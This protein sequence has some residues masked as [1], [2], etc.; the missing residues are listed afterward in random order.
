MNCRF[1]EDH[2]HLYLYGELAAAEEENVEAHLAACAHCT[3]LLRQEKAL[4]AL[5]KEEDLSAPVGLLARNRQEL[6]DRLALAP[7][8]GIVDRVRNWGASL[9]PARAWQPALAATLLLAGYIGGRIHM[10]P[11]AVEANGQEV[12]YIQLD[13]ASGQL[14]VGF[15][16]LMPREVR[17]SM[18]DEQ[19]RRLVLSAASSAADPALR[20]E[21]IDLLAQ[22]NEASDVR[23]ALT[24]TLLSDPE[25]AVRLRALTSLRSRAQD[26][27]VRRAVSQALLSDRDV[28]VRSTAIDMLTDQPTHFDAGTFQELII[29][30]DDADVRLRCQRALAG[31]KASPGIF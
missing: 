21:T 27:F 4:H 17:G 9:L 12:R 8:I 13:P 30:S 2:L 11:A 19:V 14:R 31:M 25:P 26:E 20:V 1:V 10:A 16:D 22:R 15:H 5:M 28:N 18:E 7:R 24:A 3:E 6:N 23:N 29:Q